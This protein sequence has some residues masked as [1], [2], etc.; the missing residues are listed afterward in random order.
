MKTLT[1]TL[2]FLFLTTLL[3]AQ[4]EAT[5]LSTWTDN[6]ITPT[7]WLDGRYNDVWGYAKDDREYA[8]IGSTE[9]VH[10]I[11]VTDPTNPIELEN[12]FVQGAATGTA[13]VHRDFHDYGGYLYAVADEGQ[14]TLQIIDMNNL[15]YTT[16]VVYDESNLILRAHNVFVDSSEAKLYACGIRTGNGAS[17]SLG[18]FSLT[19]P[20]DPLLLSYYTTADGI[21][22]VHDMYVRNDTAY[23]NCGN[24][25]MYV[26][27]FD[28]FA[29]PDLLGQ[30][31]N[32]PQNG[33][34][35]SGW[36]DQTGAYYY[37]A[38]ENHGLDIKT[39]DICDKDEIFVT[40]FF[41]AD[42]TSSSSIVHNLLIRCNL[43]YA[44]YYYEGLQV[45]DISDPDNVQR[46]AFYDT[47]PQADGSS[48]KGAWGV[49]PFLPSGNILVS[50]MQNGLF[51][52]E[53]L[54]ENCD[55]SIYTPCNESP[56]ATN[57]IYD[58]V[59]WKIY[60]QPA[61]DQLTIE[62]TSDKD[63]GDME[64]VINDVTGKN[65]L[66]FGKQKI[67]YGQ[68]QLTFNKINVLQSGFY[69]MTAQNEDFYF[70]QKVLIE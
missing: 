19:D 53:A 5:L 7:S 35:H 55:P 2:I 6:S 30:M 37:L 15:P 25:G 36:L 4:T 39:V 27:N 49:Y 47:Y 24:S 57:E 63:L 18:I 14:S 48:Y 28:D 56:V 31:N 13:L 54:V 34:N 66:S 70:S 45:F 58:A 21:P 22:N 38:D 32:Y 69:I 40:N 51:V 68:N 9:G 42:A 46:V 20:T 23:L 33:Y 17:K 16:E 67:Q 62:L 65:V 11:D 44:S 64:F 10:F 8:I 50:D 52:F 60:P 29:N 61:S 12:A 59:D 1:T 3:S 26:Y 41:D 43:L